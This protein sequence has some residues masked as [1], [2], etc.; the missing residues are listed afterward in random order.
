MTYWLHT[1]NQNFSRKLRTRK[2]MISEKM[3]NFNVQGLEISYHRH[4]FIELSSEKYNKFWIHFCGNFQLKSFHCLSILIKISEIKDLNDMKFINLW[5]Y[6][7]YVKQTKLLLF[8]K[9][10]VFLQIRKNTNI[11]F[12]EFQCL[13][14][15]KN[16]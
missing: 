9:I 10:R 13:K 7:F 14:C 12:N 8:Q 3:S 1:I 11:F 2:I 4:V 15:H 16:P 5:V 6:K